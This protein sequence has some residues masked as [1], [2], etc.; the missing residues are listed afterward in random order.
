MAAPIF[1]ASAAIVASASG[2]PS[3]VRSGSG[4]LIKVGLQDDLRR[5]LV[6][7]RLVA[8]LAYAGIG[9]GGGRGFG[10]VAFV[11]QL[12]LEPETSFQPPREFLRTRR[13]RMR[14]SVGV[15]RED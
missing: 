14:R 7:Q 2:R 5:D 3:P 9:E 1:S 8:A 15:G 10:R 6:A 13:H 12:D 4:T 11:D